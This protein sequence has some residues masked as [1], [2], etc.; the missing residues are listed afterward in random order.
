MRE[1]TANHPGAVPDDPGEPPAAVAGP[2]G[3]GDT[4][5]AVRDLGGRGATARR[6]PVPPVSAGVV[7]PAGLAACGAAGTAGTRGPG[8]V[9]DDAPSR[10]ASPWD[11]GGVGTES[12]ID[13]DGD[14]H[15]DTVLTEH[16]DELLVSTDLD[17]DGVADRVVGI[18][19]DGIGIGTAVDAGQP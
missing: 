5:A 12:G 6:R 15:P 8:A 18:G 9:P 7:A 3:P 17:G 2:P 11:I 19:L 14:G 1:P 16:G 4:P 10:P 13:T